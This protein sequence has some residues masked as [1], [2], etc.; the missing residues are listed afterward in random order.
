MNEGR[1]GLVS[2]DSPIGRRRRGQESAT[3]LDGP[4]RRSRLLKQRM[5]RPEDP[6]QRSS[7][8][9]VSLPRRESI[10]NSGGLKEEKG[11]ED[12]HLRADAGVVVDLSAKGLEAG[13]D[14]EDESP[15]MVEREGKVD[16]DF[17][18]LNGREGTRGERTHQLEK[19]EG[20]TETRKRVYLLRQAL[21]RCG[22]FG[23]CSRW[24]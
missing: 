6:A 11:K 22:W 17:V 19:V 10:A 13:E 14:D 24:R 12:E 3:K 16:E 20:G 7:S 9:N 23:R 21:L 4:A 1:L 2:K 15:G 5:D 18:E 8:G